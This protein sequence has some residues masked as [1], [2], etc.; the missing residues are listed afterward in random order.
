MRLDKFLKVSRLIKRRT[1][2]K[3]ACLAKCIRIN[4]RI[5]KAGDEVKITDEIEINLTNKILRVKVLEVPL[6]NIL[7]KQAVFLYEVLKEI[8]KKEED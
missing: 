6:K 3:K 4:D 5:A 7:A 1:E 8:K 2:A